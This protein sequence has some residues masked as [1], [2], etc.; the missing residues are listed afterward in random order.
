M[1]KMSLSTSDYDFW[2]PEGSRKPSKDIKPLKLSDEFWFEIYRSSDK[3]HEF[4]LHSK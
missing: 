4:H 2:N 1:N 3:L